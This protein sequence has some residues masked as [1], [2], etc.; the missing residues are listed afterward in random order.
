MPF[1]SRS[2]IHQDTQELKDSSADRAGRKQKFCLGGFL[3]F[4]R[5]FSDRHGSSLTVSS[6]CFV[7]WFG[8]TWFDSLIRSSQNV[9]LT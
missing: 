2:V 3:G 9:S 4:V 1:I 5:G 7:V 8:F 6:D